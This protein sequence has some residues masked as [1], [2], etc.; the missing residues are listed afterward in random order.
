MRECVDSLP[1]EGLPQW[2]PAAQGKELNDVSVQ[3]D[4]RPDEAMAP[5]RIYSED[6]SQERSCCSTIADTQPFE[7][8]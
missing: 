4:L 6:M 8:C 2:F 1:Q 7:S 5:S 3:I